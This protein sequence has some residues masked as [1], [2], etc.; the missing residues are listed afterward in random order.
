M[1]FTGERYVSGLVG[2][3]Q[4]EHY[5]RYLLALRF[6]RG[7]DV[8]DVASGEGFGSAI[9]GQVARSVVGVDVDAGSVRFAN[10][11]YLSERVSF[12]RGDATAL[13]V[14]DC[15][16]DVIVSFETIEHLTDH[17][18]F[19]AEI[20]RVLRPDG[21]LVISSPD[22]KVYSEDSHT[23]N[24]FHLHE[25][26]RREFLDKLRA[27]FTRVTLLEQRAFSGSVIARAAE[28]GGAAEVEGFATTDGLTFERSV[29]IPDCP[30][31]VAVA[32]NAELPAVP[33]SVMHTPRVAWHM[34]EMR[35]RAEK[36]AEEA[37]V[38]AAR[39][40]VE[41]DLRGSEVERLVAELAHAAAERDLRGSEKDRL[42]AELAH[43]AA[44]RDL[45]GN[46]VDRLAAELTHAAAERDLHR[47]EAERLAVEIARLTRESAEARGALRQV[48]ESTTWRASRPAR[49]LLSG[50]PRVARALRG[51]LRLATWTLSGK[52]GIRLRERQERHAFWR[53]ALALQRAGGIDPTWYLSNNPDIAASGMD[54]AY[55]YVAHGRAEGRG[56]APPPPPP[57]EAPG[58]TLP[59][60]PQ[61][62][63][64]G[65]RE[66]QTYEPMANRIAEDR[67]QQL[68]E[69]RPEPLPIISLKGEELVELALRLEFSPE[70]RPLVS[71]IV[72]V[73]NNLRLTMECL[74]SIRRHTDARTP[75]EVVLADDAS[76]DDS[77]MVLSQIRNVIYVRNE[78]NL[79]F[80][81]NCN[82][83]ARHARGEFVL[84]LNND[85]QVTG[86]WLAALVEAFSEKPNVG[87][88]GPRIVYPSGHLQEA[89]VAVN[90]DCS[91]Q[92]IGLSDDAS[93][94][95]Y[96]F[97]RRVDYCSGACLMLRREVFTE[98]GGFS[99][100][101]RPAYYE[102]LDLCLKLR[103]RGLATWYVPEAV[104]LHHLSKTVDA[105]SNDYK[106][107]CIVANQQKLAERWQAEVDAM[108]RVRLFA[109]Y[110]PQF[111]PIPEND[112]WWGKGFTEWTN[113]TRAVPQYAGHWQP[114]L[115][116][117]L[118]FYDL[119][120]PEV[121]AE[122]AA[123]A[124]RYGIEGF[125]F[126]YYWFGGKR[127]L[128]TP[129]EAMLGSDASDFPFLLCWANENWTRRW[130]GTDTEILMA[131][132]YSDAD[133][134]AV[135]YDL[136][137]YF[138]DP[139]YVRVDGRPMLLVYRVGLFPDFAQTSAMW[140]R[141]CRE[142]GI[143]E[144]YLSMVASF[145]DSS[146]PPSPR[147]FGCDAVVQFPPHGRAV[148]AGPQQGPANPDFGNVVFDYEASVLNYLRQP[149]PAAPYFPGV[150][151]SWDNTARRM[152]QATVFH[153]ATPGAFQAWLE[154]AIR[155]SRE[156]NSGDERIVFIN[157]WNEWAEGAHL[158]PDRMFGHA[159]LEAVRNALLA[160]THR[161]K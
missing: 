61:V 86:G 136:M 113:V 146:K 82:G 150:M 124:R 87:A 14:A 25:L 147:D 143:G 33:H 97:A 160:H 50:Y 130:D 105:L 112:R 15:S 104:I 75:Y 107:R 65:H 95:R 83:A 145:E 9:L 42:A 79:G 106:M 93:D 32:S 68:A 119:R 76:T 1:P 126:Y 103:E 121:L 108:N 21:R 46:E 10:E 23:K 132:S 38:E 11:N 117:D 20:H 66:W 70:E 125:C 47:N 71:I 5:H 85:V 67:A 122:Q 31:L 60:N 89:G 142:E 64:D 90:V 88:A 138:R 24:A 52:L 98:V 35:Q 131:Q 129:V 135:I 3:I 58:L 43:A 54:P 99:E 114:R 123:L 81:M 56:P 73:F 111:H 80:L 59:A 149:A 137:R 8:L 127:L 53:E 157:A 62:L 40:A 27:N 26:G 102:D 63:A 91:A 57:A 19:L 72:P 152:A 128:E 49:Q 22:R 30:Y 140:R 29:G 161:V 18:A 36:H 37:R 118:G 144:I 7:L 69:V 101:L 154:E 115:P 77:S 12:R 159:N 4:S 109:F 153:G 100:Y 39:L 156:H 51:S 55:H 13:P 6:A 2:D 16:I 116:A 34:E 139:R 44:E 17:D 92:M 96:N 28:T 134:R 141:L 48:A 45:R 158:E 84:F 151:P 155:R 148:P 94:P 110:L 41:R 133:S 120:R 74:L 78:E